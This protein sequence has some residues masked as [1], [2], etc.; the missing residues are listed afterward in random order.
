[1]LIKTVFDENFQTL[2][3]VTKTKI[4]KKQKTIEM[5]ETTHAI[6]KKG[7]EMSQKRMIAQEMESNIHVHENRSR[8]RISFKVTRLKQQHTD[9][10]FQVME[11]N[12]S[13]RR[14]IETLLEI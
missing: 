4:E 12:P 7:W 3:E 2:D 10:C 9:M 14:P 13:N 11:S 8:I 1:M 6:Y 5:H